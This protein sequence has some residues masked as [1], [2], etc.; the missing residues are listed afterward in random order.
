MFYTLEKNTIDIYYSSIR[1]L[2]L[3]KG[4]KLTGTGLCKAIM[5]EA[6]SDIK[7]P[8]DFL[9][10]AETG[11]L[12]NLK[13][14]KRRDEFI[15]SRLI[16]KNLL[17]YNLNSIPK[18]ILL[19]RNEY[20]K[21][22]LTDAEQLKFNITHSRSF[23]ACAATLE[24]EI[25]IDVEEESRDITGVAKSFFCEAETAYLMSIAQHLRNSEACRLWTMKESYVKA[26]G[27]GMTVPFDSF[28]VLGDKYGFFYTMKLD[29]CCY[30]SVSVPGRINDFTVRTKEIMIEQ[31]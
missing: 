11:Y 12:C 2:Q 23:V 14:K 29:G 1:N 5:R 26:L 27:K 30:L 24:H 16:L 9:N 19:T 20:G 17:A 18:D 15:Y 8:E 6:F 22:Y 28:N 21:P 31:Y 13:G 25:G 10:Q 3:S 4:C 7:V